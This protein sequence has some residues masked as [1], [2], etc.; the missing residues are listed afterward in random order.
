M[1]ICRKGVIKGNIFT[2]EQGEKYKILNLFAPEA[3]EC[4]IQLEPICEDG[5]CKCIR[6]INI[7]D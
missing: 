7:N 5:R 4:Y 2:S 6:K 3:N 1:L